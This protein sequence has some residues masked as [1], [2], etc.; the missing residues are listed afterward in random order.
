LH[1]HRRRVSERAWTQDVY[2]VLPEPPREQSMVMQRLQ[3]LVPHEDGT[4]GVHWTMEGVTGDDVARAIC[5]ATEREGVDLVCLGTSAGKRHSE[6]FNDSVARALVAR[7]RR[8]VVVL[9]A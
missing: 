8:P 2:G 5:Q 6:Y 1:V 7:C 9:H 4:Q 3:S